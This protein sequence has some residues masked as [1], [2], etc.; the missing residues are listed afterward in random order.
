MSPL[1]FA[2]FFMAGAAV[3][4][5]WFVTRYQRHAPESL[6]SVAAHLVVANVATSAAFSFLVP[7]IG[8]VG[9]T[10]ALMVVTFPPLVYFFVTCAW[11][12]LFVQRLATSSSR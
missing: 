1:A 7:A 3:V 12:L 10:T 4:G 5:L 2:L 6:L 11:L 9:T 8:L